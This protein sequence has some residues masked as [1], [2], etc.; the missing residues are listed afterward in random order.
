[1]FLG[2]DSA[3]LVGA[4][5]ADAAGSFNVA[6]AVAVLFPPDLCHPG[7]EYVFQASPAGAGVEAGG[8]RAV[9]AI[10]H[11]GVFEVEPSSGA[12]GQVTLRLAGRDLRVAPGTVLQLAIGEADPFAHV[13][14]EIGTV[15]V[16]DA[17]SFET[18][19]NVNAFCDEPTAIYATT[20]R[21]P[22]R[23]KTVY[24]GTP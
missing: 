10:P 19:I 3:S 18:E 11:I 2:L 21:Y 8:P 24:T 13:F 1:M 4:A 5:T 12:C 15:T 9:L 23:W 16:D 22:V 6:P 20:D 17:E 7:Y 14:A